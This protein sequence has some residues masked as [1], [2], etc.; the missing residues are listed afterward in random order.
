MPFRVVIQKH[1]VL[2][3][4]ELQQQTTRLD[5][6]WALWTVAHGFRLIAPF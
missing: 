5:F 6:I 4:V 3:N 1:P 2:E